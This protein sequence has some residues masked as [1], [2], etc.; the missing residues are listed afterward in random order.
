METAGE[1]RDRACTMRR[2]AAGD[3]VLPAAGGGLGCPAGSESIPR[4][5]QW[6]PSAAPNG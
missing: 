4:V 3:E 5:R 2:G 6:R 1:L